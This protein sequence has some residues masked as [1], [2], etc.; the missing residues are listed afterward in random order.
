MAEVRVEAAEL[1]RILDAIGHTAKDG[2]DAPTRVVCR[3]DD[4][5]YVEVR[6]HDFGVRVPIAGAAGKG[7]V[8]PVGCTALHRALADVD[9]EVSLSGASD[10]LRFSTADSARTLRTVSDLRVPFDGEPVLSAEGDQMRQVAQRAVT[11]AADDPDRPHLQVVRAESGEDGVWLVATDAFKLG[12]F[13]LPGALSAGEWSLSLPSEGLAR[14]LEHG[15]GGRVSVY[16][17]GGWAVI[18]T[19]LACWSLRLRDGRFPDWRHALPQLNGHQPLRTRADALKHAVAGVADDEADSVLL[20]ARPGGLTLRSQQ[21]QEHPV[22]VSGKGPRGDM[23]L[24]M[25]PQLL[26]EVLAAAGDGELDLWFMGPVRPVLLRRGDDRM[27]VMPM[28]PD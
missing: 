4:R 23:Q 10:Q 26:G 5:A 27:L 12:A 14:V 24:R 22:A 28:R 11:L 2:V 6:A 16:A 3:P 13:T 7:T 19:G 15:L 20:L 9:G 25:S 1:R 17:A 21:G 18:D 8:G